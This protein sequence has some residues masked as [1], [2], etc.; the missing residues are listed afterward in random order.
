[1]RG[2]NQDDSEISGMHKQQKGMP[3]TMERTE[4]EVSKRHWKEKF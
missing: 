4:A 2:G 3:A 1:M